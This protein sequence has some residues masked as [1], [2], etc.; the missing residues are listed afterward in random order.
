MLRRA[1]VI[2]SGSGVFDGTE[3]H[4][5]SAVLVALS[6]NNVQYDCFAPDI[7]QAHV[8]DH[9]AGAPIENQTRNVLSESGRI[10]RGKITNL[11]ELLNSEKFNQYNGVI[12]PGGFG[13]AKNLSNFALVEDPSTMKINETVEQVLK[14]FHQNK[15]PIGMCCIAPVIAAKM[16]PGASL[17]MGGNTENDGEWPYAGAAQAAENVLGAKYQVTSMDQICVD[18]ENKLVTSAA[19]MNDK[20]PVHVIHDNVGLMVKGVVDLMWV[21]EKNLIY[22]S[23]FFL[24]LE[25]KDKNS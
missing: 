3:I 2:L 1:A 9:A 18:D 25:I 23:F 17:T 10:A 20:V 22:C 21:F 15:K 16:F 24:F 6:R 8:I 12:I 14:L 5:A 13:A 11:A 4:E 19:Y 7:N